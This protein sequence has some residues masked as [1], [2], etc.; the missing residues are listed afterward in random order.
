VDLFEKAGGT[1]IFIQLACSM[2]QFIVE[3]LI[4]IVMLGIFVIT[5]G[6]ATLAFIYPEEWKTFIKWFKDHIQSPLLESYVGYGGTEDAGT[7][8][9][10]AATSSVSELLGA[11][12]PSN[13]LIQQGLA[14]GASLFIQSY[15]SL[16][17]TAT[18]GVSLPYDPKSVPKDVFHMKQGDTYTALYG[19]NIT[20][21]TPDTPISEL[22]KG[23]GVNPETDPVYVEINQFCMNAYTKC[24]LMDL[25]EV[26][27]EKYLNCIQDKYMTPKFT[28]GASFTGVS[29]PNTPSSNIGTTATGAS[30]AAYSPSE[31]RISPDEYIPH[32]Y[33]TMNVQSPTDI[34]PQIDAIL[35]NSTA[36]PSVR[37]HIRNELQFAVNDEIKNRENNIYQINYV[38]E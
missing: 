14:A 9:I 19:S 30:A 31:I 11:P 29:L 32:R 24:V 7:N 18:K 37:Q 34:G 21:Q 25:D 8:Q 1:A 13:N 38:F 16:K 4:T 6:T 10:S 36:S 28:S 5:L 27:K 15:N 33:K 12:L 22:V 23:L 26:C 2:M 35:Q 20:G 3:C 17:D